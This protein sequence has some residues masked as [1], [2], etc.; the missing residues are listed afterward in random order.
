MGIVIEISI[1]MGVLALLVAGLSALYARWAVNEAKKAN[2]IG[3]LN[4]LFALRAHY[5]QLMDHQ[6][7]I[8]E[9]MPNGSEGFN[10]AETVYEK[11]EMHLVLSCVYAKSAYWDEIR[12]APA[13]LMM[14]G[15][16]HLNIRLSRCFP[17]TQTLLFLF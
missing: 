11:I 17:K 12:I 9:I 10:K 14:R 15:S 3:R 2:D 7:K 1:V 13:R 5:L 8:A 6:L 4:S 16:V